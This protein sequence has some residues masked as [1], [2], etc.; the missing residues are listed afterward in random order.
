MLGKYVRS[1]AA[2]SWIGLSSCVSTNVS[3]VKPKEY[4]VTL[5]KT[6][7]KFIFEY[8]QDERFSKTEYSLDYAQKLSRRGYSGFEIY[9]RAQMGLSLEETLEFIDT[10]KPDC[11]VLMTTKHR[12]LDSERSKSGGLA[13]DHFNS[14]KISKYFIELQEH[15]DVWVEFIYSKK[16]FEEAKRKVSDPDLLILAGH[17]STD[18]PS[19]SKDLDVDKDSEFFMEYIDR[20]KDDGVLVLHSCLN[21]KG[22][23]SFA[24]YCLDRLE[25][26]PGRFIY[27]SKMSFNPSE[28]EVESYYPL[29]VKFVESKMSLGSDDVSQ[30]SVID[31]TFTNR[32]SQEIEDSQ[33]PKVPENDIET[34]DISI[35]REEDITLIS[36]PREINN[37]ANFDL[38]RFPT[39]DLKIGGV[40]HYLVE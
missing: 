4:E 40:E 25:K 33:D 29:R 12:T 27:A 26:K 28:F 3:D 11:V 37:I 15:Y 21:A 2:A 22:Q 34:V 13:Y 20:I 36:I 8:G 1:L 24:E 17:G 9:R 5:A 38:D 19:V 16:D 6:G 32:P 31:Y 7:G 14:P 23:N 35:F 39:F 30:L 18:G 10:D